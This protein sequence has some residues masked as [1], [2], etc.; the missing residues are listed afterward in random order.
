MTATKCN[1]TGLGLKPVIDPEIAS[2]KSALSGLS[3]D[4]LLH[5][6]AR[7]WVHGRRLLVLL[8]D[9]TLDAEAARRVAIEAVTQREDERDAIARQARSETASKAGKASK[10]RF[11]PLEETIKREYDK[12]QAGQSTFSSASHF[13][14]AMHSRDKDVAK[15]TIQ[16]WCTRWK[17]EKAMS[18]AS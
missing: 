3:R 18:P 16:R 2:A 8:E 14:L 13:A 15:S 10:L 9:R 6:A 4:A 7:D 1:G 17:K 5:M 12:W 11:G